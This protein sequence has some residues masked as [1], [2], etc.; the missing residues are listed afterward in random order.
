MKEKKLRLA[1]LGKDVSQSSSDK[2]HRFILGKKG[3]EVEYERV[4]AL[5][6]DFDFAVRRLLG[7]FD[8]FNVTIPYKRDIMEYLDGV[9]GDAFSFGA[10]NTVVCGSRLGYNTDGVGFLQMLRFAGVDVAGKTCLIVGAGGAGR[11]VATTLK[12]SGASVSLY[13]RNRKELEETC[14]E[15][16][17]SVAEKLTGYQIII[18]ASGVGMHD[19]EGI[20]PVGSESFFGAEA[21]IDLIYRPKQSE[22]LRLAKE[23]GIRT[24]NGEAMLFFQAYYSDCLYLGQEP[25]KSE[26]DELYLAYLQGEKQ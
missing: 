13:R 25:S 5:S 15:L 21:A 10:V 16:G 26:M 19:T 17:V 3:Y 1:L 24:V 11:S 7:D 8:G 6:S 18:N 2:I 20:S 23:Q 22:F 9:E 12:Q 4:S 14:L